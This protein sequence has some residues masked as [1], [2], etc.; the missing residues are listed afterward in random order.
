VRR[1]FA[2]LDIPFAVHMMDEA[3]AQTRVALAKLLPTGPECAQALEYFEPNVPWQADFLSFRT[4]CYQALGASL[5]PAALRD[6]R[7]FRGQN[8]ELFPDQLRAAL[9]GR[10]R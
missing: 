4:S 1:L 5:A 9:G 10:Q 8:P 2:L 6:L 7:E 3:R